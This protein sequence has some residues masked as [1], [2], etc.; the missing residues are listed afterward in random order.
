MTVREL[1]ER[2]ETIKEQDAIVGVAHLRGSG[3]YFTDIA[4]PIPVSAKDFSDRVYLMDDEIIKGDKSKAPRR[5]FPI[6]T[7][8]DSDLHN[9]ILSKQECLENQNTNPDN[10]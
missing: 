9:I 6:A 7:M 5:I 10:K 2:L 4:V 8:S 1:R 3:V